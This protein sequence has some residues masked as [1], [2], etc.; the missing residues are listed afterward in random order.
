VI[1]DTWY[2]IELNVRAPVPEWG[3][4]ELF[5]GAEEDV[6]VDSAGRVSWVLQRQ[7]D[8]HLIR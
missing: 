1:P 7:S 3:G 8:Y 2:S 4:Q 5:I 6:N